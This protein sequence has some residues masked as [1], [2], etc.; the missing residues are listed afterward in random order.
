MR[1]YNPDRELR[2]SL[3]RFAF[4]KQRYVERGI[5]SQHHVQFA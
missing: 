1:V 4:R 2:P 5:V 3:S